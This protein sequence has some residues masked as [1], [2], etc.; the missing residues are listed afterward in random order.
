MRKLQIKQWSLVILK[1]G[2]FE[3]NGLPI[4]NIRPRF[5]IYWRF[6]DKIS[7]NCIKHHS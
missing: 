7:L 5:S 1:H 2:N 3:R 4:T 6:F